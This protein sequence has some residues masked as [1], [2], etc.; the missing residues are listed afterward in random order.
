MFFY[1][2]GLLDLI[3]IDPI[4]FP[5]VLLEIGSI[6]DEMTGRDLVDHVVD[7]S[8]SYAVLFSFFIPF[9]TCFIGLDI[10]NF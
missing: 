1:F 4:S 3:G 2:F 6:C 9:P 7:R 8:G 5:F 10:F